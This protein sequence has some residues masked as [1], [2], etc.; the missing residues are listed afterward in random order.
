MPFKGGVGG[1]NALLVSKGGTPA[2]RFS[3][4]ELVLLN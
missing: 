3:T 1:G 2:P 4:T